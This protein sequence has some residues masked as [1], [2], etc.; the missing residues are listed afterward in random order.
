[1][2]RRWV[3]AANSTQQMRGPDHSAIWGTPDSPCAMGHTRLSLVDLASTGDQPMSAMGYTISYNGEIYNH[4]ELRARCPAYHFTGTS[5]TESLLA[6]IVVHGLAD[7]LPRLNGMFAFALWDERA[8]ELHMV[9]DRFG[10]KPLY[11]YNH[12]GIVACASSSAALLHL[13]QQWDVDRLGVAQFFALG[14]STRGVWQGITRIGGGLLISYD[15]KTKHQHAYRWYTPTFNPNA[16]DELPGLI[17]DAIRLTATADVP[18]GLFYSGGVDTSVVAMHMR[19]AMAFHLD[20]AER[21]Y[22]ITGAAHFGLNLRLVAPAPGDVLPALKDI[23]AQSGEPTMAGHIPWLV[24]REAA[25]AVKACISGNGADELFFGYDRTPTSMHPEALRKQHSHLYRDAKA[26]GSTDTPCAVPD[27]DSEWPDDAWPRWKELHTYVQHDLNPTLDA[28]SMCHGLEL[29][30]PFLDHRVVE[31]ALSLPHSYHGNKRVLKDMLRTAG[32]PA[33]FIDRPK[34]GF[35]YTTSN[36]AMNQYATKA[37][38]W[39]CTYMGWH[40]NGPRSARDRNY[41][42]LCAAGFRAWHSV[43]QHRIAA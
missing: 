5:D 43:H 25:T 6:H 40:A 28:A 8:Q 9:T 23:A 27:L 17:A 10:I 33:T 14:G 4:Q 41:L 32:L 37:W 12:S 29:R 42:N 36:L 13:Q 11:V 31:A 2:N 22:A 1:M 7:T 15:H 16:A 35:S 26:Y 3:A 20:G 38:E 39:A 18:V 19:G 24:A 30:V 21:E 34:L